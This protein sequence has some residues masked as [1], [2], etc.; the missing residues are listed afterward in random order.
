MHTN[1]HR[2]TNTN[3]ITGRQNMQMA[4]YAHCVCATNLILSKPQIDKYFNLHNKHTHIDAHTHTGILI[5]YFNWFSLN[6]L[7]SFCQQLPAEPQRSI[8]RVTCRLQ[9][10]ARWL[11]TLSFSPYLPR[12]LFHVFPFPTSLLPFPQL[13]C[14]CDCVRNIN[15]A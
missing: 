1:T 10:I 8:I 9:L 12:S 6:L 15:N 3:T 2:N 14:M 11:F 13:I 5:V 7:I 4:N